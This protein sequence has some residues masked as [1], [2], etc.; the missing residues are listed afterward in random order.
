VGLVLLLAPMLPFVG[1]EVNGARIWIRIPGL[2]QFQPGEFA[3]L[4]LA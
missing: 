3:K 2:G 1:Q 4:F